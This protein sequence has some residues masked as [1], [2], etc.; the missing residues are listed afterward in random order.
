M[1]PIS[2]PAPRVLVVD[3]EP[4]LCRLMTRTLAAAGF[5]ARHIEDPADALDE[6]VDGALD[7]DCLVVDLRMP[8]LNG[9]EMLRLL[10]RVRP[11]PP[12]LLV[13]GY[14]D[15][16]PAELDQLP[17]RTRFLR[18]PFRPDALVT[19]LTELLGLD[20]RTLHSVAS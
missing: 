7:V 20:Q 11:L 6:L 17:V 16:A 1:P 8:G 12:V 5:Q 13:S 18:K 3:D 15:V 9:I 14:A 19:M 10:D 4:V 2:Q